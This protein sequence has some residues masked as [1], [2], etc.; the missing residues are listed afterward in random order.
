MQSLFFLLTE[1]LGKF[2]NF[3]KKIQ[4]KLDQFC[5]F[6]LGKIGQI[7]DISKFG[8]WG[9]MKKRRWGE[10]EFSRKKWGL[11]NSSFEVLKEFHQD[12]ELRPDSIFFVQML[13]HLDFLTPGI[14]RLTT[15]VGCRVSGN[16]TWTSRSRSRVSRS[17]TGIRG[18]GTSN[19]PSNQPPTA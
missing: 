13:Q 18:I 5:F 16:R 8:N 10:G 1:K 12:L 9:K 6:F 4:C 7:L 3:K 14:A 19:G 2:W 11:L 15:R 17:S